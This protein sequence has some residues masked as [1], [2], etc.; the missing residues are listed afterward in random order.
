MFDPWV[1]K[2]SWRRKWQIAPVFLPGKSHGQRRLMGYSPWRHKE[3]DMAKQLGMHAHTHAGAHTH[4]H[5]HTH[6]HWSLPPTTAPTLVPD[7]KQ[8]KVSSIVVLGESCVPTF[9]L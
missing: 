3:S 6:T 1:R 4:T 2:I 7:K 8:L 5:T 9:N